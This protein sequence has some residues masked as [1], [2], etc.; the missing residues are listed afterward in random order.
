MQTVKT[1][2]PKIAAQQNAN[3]PLLCIEGPT[4]SGKSALAEVFAKHID[5]EIISADSMQIYKGMD[6]G[7][8]KQPEQK[9]STTYYCIDICDPGQ[10]YSAALFQRDAR[11]AIKKIETKNKRPIICGGTGFYVRAVIDDMQFVSGTQMDNPIREKYENI[12]KELGEHHG[13]EYVYKI[14]QEKDPESAKLV[15]PHNIKRV[16]RALEMH[17][18]GESYAAR[19]QNFKKIEPWRKSVRFALLVQPEILAERINKRVDAMIRAGLIDE[20]QGLLDKGFRD[21]LCAPQAIGYKEIVSYLDKEISKQEAIELIK[22][23]TRRYAK[24]QRT[25]LRSQKDIIWLCADSLKDKDFEKLFA[26]ALDRYE[27]ECV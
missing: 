15:H 21:G 22:L 20:V 6:I 11:N 2:A 19:R 18:V 4:G 14:L 7:T 12:V 17:E 9:R 16:I 23:H 26:T 24:R 13:G 27:Q 10:P 8:A 25:W 3:N 5:G 1:Q